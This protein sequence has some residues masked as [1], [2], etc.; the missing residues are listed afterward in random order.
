MASCPPLPADHPRVVALSP[1]ELSRRNSPSFV[2]STACWRRYVGTWE[3]RGGRLYL[4]G[5]VGC[6]EMRGAE[7][8]LAEWFSGLLHIPRG[9]LLKYI[10]MG[11][12]SVY[13][14]DLYVRI[15]GGVVVESWT[16]DNRSRFAKDAGAAASWWRK[17]FGRRQT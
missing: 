17:L 4:T 5:V 13:E 12:E 1:E 8:I 3:V 15:E 9:E 10:H 11:F 14:Q 16:V 6:Y 7:P 2:N